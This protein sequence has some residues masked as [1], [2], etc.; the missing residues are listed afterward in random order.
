LKKLFN[1]QRTIESMIQCE[2]FLSLN[3]FE[4]LSTLCKLIAL[5][6][7]MNNSNPYYL[8]KNSLRSLSILLLKEAKIKF[9]SLMTEHF[10]PFYQRFLIVFSINLNKKTIKIVMNQAFKC[11]KCSNIQLKA[12]RCVDDGTVLVECDLDIENFTE[13]SLI[14]PINDNRENDFINYVRVVSDLKNLMPVLKPER[15]YQKCFFVCFLYD[16]NSKR[17]LIYHQIDNIRTG[18]DVLSITISVFLPILLVDTGTKISY[19]YFLHEKKDD[20]IQILE[21]INLIHNKKL[22]FIDS[23]RNQFSSSHID[24]LVLFQNLEESK[25]KKMKKESMIDHLD[26]ILEILF[27]NPLNEHNNFLSLMIKIKE[28][29]C[30]DPEYRQYF[31]EVC[32]SLILNTEIDFLFL[33]NLKNS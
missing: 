25:I 1:E 13:Q 28:S 16:S 12:Q 21:E 6:Q 20:K 4:H 8:N 5:H 7:H 29:L 17:A 9:F 26:E 18:S 32:C 22:R 14:S 3:L 27:D 19:Y 31:C 10:L 30:C 11:P 2:A 33:S 15:D 23:S 24:G